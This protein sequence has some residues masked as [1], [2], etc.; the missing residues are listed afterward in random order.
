MKFIY[1]LGRKVL[2][3]KRFPD[4]S[5]LIEGFRVANYRKIMCSWAYGW[6][7]SWPQNFV[8][9]SRIQ[10]AF[11]SRITNKEYHHYM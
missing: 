1:S 7:D 6:V 2:W 5:T 10:I 4:S 11:N 8:V 9:V 3:D